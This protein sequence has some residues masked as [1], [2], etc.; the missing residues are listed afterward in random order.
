MP[1]ACEM[2]AKGRNDV[3]FAFLGREDIPMDTLKSV[4][5]ITKE[6]EVMFHGELLDGF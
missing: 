4:N 5:G 2:G 3:H 6:C 1:I